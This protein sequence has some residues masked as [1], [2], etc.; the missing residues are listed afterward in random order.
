[1]PED[2]IVRVHLTPDRLTAEPLL[3]SV[4]VVID[5]LRATTTII[6]ALAAG[7]DAV[8]P[9]AEVEEARGVADQMRAGH[10][11]LG[12]ERDGVPPAGFDLGNSPTEYTCARCKGTTLVLTTTNGTRALLR[13]AAAARTLVAGFVNY[14]AVC[15]QLAEDARPVDIVCAGF[16]GE[17]AMDDA[18][19]AGALVEFLCEH[20]PVCLNDAAR[21]A[22]DCFENHGRVLEGALEV[23]A[24][25]A[26]LRS[27]GYD[28]DIRTAARVDQFALVP[29]VRR[30]PLRVEIGAVGIV[31]NHWLK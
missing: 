23:S 15:E 9:I 13:A 1:M 16:H 30:D 20:G 3:N 18:L 6:H 21:L 28:E 31:K 29:E 19:L 27:L 25:G 12:G 2:R 22:W 26:H 14:S 24:G 17:V 8:W 5:V 10:V 7:C 4:A 11:L